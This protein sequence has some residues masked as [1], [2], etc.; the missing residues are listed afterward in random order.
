[1]QDLTDLHKL[2]DLMCLIPRKDRQNFEKVKQDQKTV[3]S[4]ETDTLSDELLQTFN[5]L[6]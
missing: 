5:F 3:C 1:M 4:L 2:F 6:P